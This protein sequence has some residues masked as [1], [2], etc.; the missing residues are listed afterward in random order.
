MLKITPTETSG[1]QMEQFGYIAGRKG[2]ARIMLPITRFLRAVN[3]ERYI[4]P[5]ERLL[6]I[7]C[8]DGYFLRRSTCNERYGLDK[9]TGDDVVDTLHFP[10]C[11][12]DYVTMLAVIEHIADPTA[13]VKEIHRVLKP[14][15]RFIFTTPKQRAEFLIRFYVKNIDEEHEV[16]Y[17]RDSVRQ[18][19]GNFFDLFGHH[20]YMFG[21]N[22]VFCLIKK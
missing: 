6:D 7:G 19:A 22:Q 20:T 18:L 16:Y 15:G 12:F 9:R 13:L 21:L 14:G 10:G 3:A 4:E 17:D 1:A 5:R 2:I 11:Y 8:G